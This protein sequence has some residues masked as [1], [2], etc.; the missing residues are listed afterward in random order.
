MPST[1]T[2]TYGATVVE[3]S[4]RLQWTNEYE[5]SPVQQDTEYTLGGALVVDQG[6]KLAGRPILLEG[7]ETN[8]WITRTQCEAIKS[9]NAIPR[10][11]MTLIL[12]GE[13]HQVIFDRASGGFN[14]RPIW[15]LL[16][17]EIT[18]ELFYVPTF[19]FLTV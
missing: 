17:G 18:S 19:R 12:R 2:L 11:E 5:W 16:D 8:A 9:L 15:K 3:L 13:E 4:D 14:A 7:E 6:V 1:I 10:A